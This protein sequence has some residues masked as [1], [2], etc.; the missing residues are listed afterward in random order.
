MSRFS[1]G[2][3]DSKRGA[4]SL[5]SFLV[6]CEQAEFGQRG[7]FKG[8]G[9]TQVS[10]PP[11][12]GSFF[13]GGNL[14]N[15]FRCSFWCPFTNPNRGSSLK[16]TNPIS[17]TRHPRGVG[18]Q[19]L[20][21]L[22]RQT[23]GCRKTP[24]TKQP[25]VLRCFFFLFFSPF[26]GLFV[27]LF[28]FPQR[29]DPRMAPRIPPRVGA[30]TAQAPF[31]MQAAAGQCLVQLTT[32]DSVFLARAEGARSGAKRGA[33]LRGGLV[34]GLRGGA[35]GGAC[36][37]GLAGGACGG[38]LGGAKVGLGLGLGWGWGGLGVCRALWRG[39]SCT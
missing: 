34:G 4:V 37:G 31:E 13:W 36:G 21:R 5:I 35:L 1:S 3:L 10:Q 23:A 33:R 16:T 17:P 32:A 12:R 30:Q 2:R 38:G 9:S 22:H 20:S 39:K 27:R 11:M 25:M 15:G 29:P 7:F 26:P 8:A 19:P 18:S 6:R 28:F 14:Q 24:S